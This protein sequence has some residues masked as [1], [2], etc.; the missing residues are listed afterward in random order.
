MHLHPAK[1]KMKKRAIAGLLSDEASEE[2][3]RTYRILKIFAAREGSFCRILDIG[4]NRGHI[5]LPIKVV[6]RAPEVF[7][8]D[9]NE[10]LLGIAQK[11]GIISFKVDIDKD[12]YPF[13]ADYF[14]A[15]FM[16]E[17]L[18]HLND[19]DHAL[20]EIHRILRLNGL[21]VI[22]TPNFA[23][24]Y[25]RVALLLGFQPYWINNS[26]EMPSAGQMIKM[27]SGSIPPQGGHTKL[28]THRAL[29]E[30]L[31]FYGFSI[32]Q[33]VSYA[34]P[35]VKKRFS[36]FNRIDK[37]MAHFGASSGIIISSSKK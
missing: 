13:E 35:I 2:F 36:L 10:E 5:S 27:R 33:D 6:S 11:K 28:Y 17:V 29:R 32:V 30:L 37:I 4:C 22:T 3:D 7:G 8:L 19:P 1:A 16:G 34:Y 31:E 24:W 15:V 18:E 20:H 12:R 9:W 26:H 25:N 14:D 21:L 23:A